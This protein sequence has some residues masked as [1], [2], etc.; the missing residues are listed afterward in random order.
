MNLELV[1]TD[2][3]LKELLARCDHGAVTMMLTNRLGNERHI[4][5]REWI[6]NSHTC[7]GL[8]ADLNE[9]IL[10]TFRE[11]VEEMDEMP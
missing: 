6:G 2:D 1:S 4:Y 9:T 7:A 5:I 8:C 11:G 3:L 10:R